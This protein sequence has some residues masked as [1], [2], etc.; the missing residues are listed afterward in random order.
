MAAINPLTREVVFKIVFYGPGLGG[1]TTSLQHI[2]DASSPDHRGKMVSL[3]TSVDRTLYF[4]FLPLRLPTVRGMGVRLQLFTVPG[5]VHYA[6]T[7]KLVVT[8]ADGVVFVADS[9]ESRTEANADSLDDLRQN[10]VEQQRDPANVPL[11]F[12]FNKRDLPGIVPMDELA[13]TLG[14]GLAPVVGS[15]AT[16]GQGVFET[17]ELVTR[18]V[19]RNFEK[20]LP[21]NQAG[22][23]AILSEER[24]IEHALRQVRLDGG[25]GSKPPAAAAPAPAF[26]AVASGGSSSVAGAASGSSA[27]GTSAAVTSSRGTAL[28]DAPVPSVASVTADAP[29][30]TNG[31]AATNGAASAEPITRPTPVS[32]APAAPPGSAEGELRDIVARASGAPG[33]ETEHA[34]IPTQVVELGRFAADAQDSAPP[35]PPL[36]I[37]SPLPSP[38]LAP[39]TR[40]ENEPPLSR[41][42]GSGP[43]RRRPSAPS[44][45]GPYEPSSSLQSAQQHH[46]VQHQQHDPGPASPAQPER[47]RSSAPVSETPTITP[48][49]AM[50]FSLA[51]LW[52]EGEREL[53]REAESAIAIRDLERAVELLDRVATRVIAST[54]AMLGTTDS[55]RDPL[56]ALSLL[57]ID[58]RRYLAF[59]ALVRDIRAGSKASDRLTLGAYAFLLELRSARSRIGL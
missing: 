4:D 9:Q 47:T 2:H 15:V 14:V 25:A 7:R 30:P 35:P 23:P 41:R 44:M 24:G 28:A 53:I 1:K 52:P 19:I 13:D 12:Q 17:L 22:D 40:P 34:S 33:V 8:G 38:P 59:R 37:P 39:S 48:V 56:V 21:A 51:E 18:A 26:S 42:V 31:V 10:L 16:T 55:P 49:P 3:A 43:P 27:T 46:P 5:Q 58:G 57:G 50:G 6:A 32:A 20:G 36:G 54:V 45:S 11:V 29:S